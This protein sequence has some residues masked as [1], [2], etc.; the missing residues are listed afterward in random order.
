[1]EER[2]PNPDELLKQRSRDTPDT[3]A[4]LKKG[5]LKIF[6]GYSAGVGKTYKMLQEAA[7]SR[8]NGTDVVIGIVETHRRKETEALVEG[9]ET[10]PRKKVAYSGLTLE[11]MDL[12]AVLKRKPGLVLVDELAHTNAPGSRHTWRYQDVTEL[13]N[14][15]IDVFTTLNIQHIESLND[16]V[17]QISGIKV[18][19]RVPDSMLEPAQEIEL[20]DLTPEK[21]IERFKE[22]KVYIP[23]KAEQAMN[24]F[25][26]KSNLLALR[27]LS[28]KYTA[29]QVDEDIRS[30]I[31]KNAVTGPWP[32]GSRLLVAI[33]P[34]PTTD[35]LLR[36]THRMAMDLD[37]QWYAVYVESPQR[38]K[39]T[40]AS[41]IQLEKNIR[42]AENLGAKV[43]LLN[44]GA[45]AD[46]ILKFSR[47]NNVTLIISGPSRR[48][49]IEKLFFGTVVDELVKKSGN[50]SVLVSGESVNEKSPGTRPAVYP[51]IFKNDFKAYLLCLLIISLFTWLGWALRARVEPVNI[52]MLLLLPSIASGILW[53]IRVGLFASLVSIFA[54]NF[55]FIPP[56]LTL[57]VSDLK[58]LPSFAVFILVS[59]A[60]SLLTKTIRQEE[61]SSKNRER[62][63]YSLYSFSREIIAAK[64]LDD[65]LS[66]AVNH[67]GEA[68]E[69]K[70]ALFAPDNAGPFVLKSKNV[71]NLFLSENELAV[72]NWSFNNG[73]PAG[74][75]TNTLSSA[76]WYYLPL[77]MQDRTIGVVGI[78]PVDESMFLTS[79]QEQLFRSFASIV[80]LAVAK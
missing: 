55:F 47:T 57:R 19:E 64:D 45:V 74:R 52:G 78:K 59:I 7:N 20:V 58:Y 36:F 3:T 8:K 62:F 77:K 43:V 53:G 15:G 21:L 27:E 34:S 2:R 23:R 54:F 35:K 71:E 18:G 39:S 40:E 41:R 12:D 9:L 75:S 50:I 48:N 37:A 4:A 70:V 31:E 11:D 24:Q 72:A 28:L 38:V 13:L 10:I 33:S 44:G 46:E 16:V 22:G 6:L 76:A 29:K 63:I 51:A 73:Q 61:N 60:I 80:A 69:S 5:S 42:L 26:K 1:M 17:Q 68:F 49:R 32:V 66:R 56:Y 30:F 79:E 25:F 67:I 14:A 65:I